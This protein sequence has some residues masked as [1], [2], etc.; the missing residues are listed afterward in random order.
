MNPWE[1]RHQF[2]L[3]QVEEMKKHKWIVSE[4]AHRDMGE[5]AF[6]EWIAKF[7]KDFRESWEMAHGPVDEFEKHDCEDVDE[8]DEREN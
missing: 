1:K 6:F 4:Q 2:M 7:A 3:D 5:A 8:N